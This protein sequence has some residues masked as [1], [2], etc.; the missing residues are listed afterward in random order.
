MKK[1]FLNT[2]M[3]LLTVLL[4]NVLYAQYQ[5]PGVGDKIYSVKEIK[6]NVSRLDRADSMVKLKGFVIKQINSDIY[7][8]KDET[9]T[10]NVEIEKENMPEKPFNDKT[11]LI[12]IGEVDYDFLEGVEIEVKQILFTKQ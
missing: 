6:D 11:E 2:V 9:G 3:V 1:L 5:G 4:S 12:L 7:L 8:F 10:I